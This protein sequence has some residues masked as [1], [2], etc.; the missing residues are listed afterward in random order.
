V[1]DPAL[2]ASLS[3]RAATRALGY[4]WHEAAE[5]LGALHDE[6]VAGHLVQC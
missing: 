6:L 4:S 1:D 3:T 2:A 5:R